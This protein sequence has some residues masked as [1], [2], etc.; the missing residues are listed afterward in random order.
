MDPFWEFVLYILALARI[1]MEFIKFD[2]NSLPLSEKLA[3]NLPV[4]RIK[5]F[6]RMGF[7]LGVGYVF[8]TT[9]HWA[10]KIK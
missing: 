5:K 2:P 10:L 8:F 3:Q 1:A 7:Y 6:H 9:L 4:G